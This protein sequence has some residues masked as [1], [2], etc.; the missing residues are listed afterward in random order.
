VASVPE[1]APPGFVIPALR[2]VVSFANARERFVQGHGVPREQLIEQH[3]G[4]PGAA[5]AGTGTPAPPHGG[6]AVEKVPLDN[7]GQV[8]ADVAASL[9]LAKDLVVVVDDF[10]VDRR[11]MLLDRVRGEAMT[12]ADELDDLIDDGEMVEELSFE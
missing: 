2:D 11:L 3:A 4:R 6:A 12:A 8:G 5:R 7:R 10:E 9:E 1:S